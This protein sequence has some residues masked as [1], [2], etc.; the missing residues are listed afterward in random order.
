MSLR[1]LTSN[2]VRKQRDLSGHFLGFEMIFAEK[3]AKNRVVSIIHVRGISSISLECARAVSCTGPVAE[4]PSL[5]RKILLIV[6]WMFLQEVAYDIDRC[7]LFVTPTCSGVG[8]SKLGCSVRLRS[9]THLT[10]R[11]PTIAPFNSSAI[12]RGI[13][14]IGASVR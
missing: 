4:S 11:I 12:S 7:R 2:L 10:P 6:S 5:Q 14:A 9:R 3:V 13:L 1:M 8:L